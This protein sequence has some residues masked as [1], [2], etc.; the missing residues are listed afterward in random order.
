M[1]ATTFTDLKPRERISRCFFLTPYNPIRLSIS[2]KLRHPLYSCSIG[3]I[4]PMAFTA[5]NVRLMQITFRIKSMQ[6]VQIVSLDNSQLV[7]VI[8][9][10]VLPHPYHKR[11]IPQIQQRRLS[12]MSGHHRRGG[13]S[14]GHPRC[15]PP[16]AVSTGRISTGP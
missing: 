12:R 4:H 14:V 2:V 11:K 13:P 9:F 3:T 5:D 1:R 15:H 7:S 8:G 6:T 16:H 10:V